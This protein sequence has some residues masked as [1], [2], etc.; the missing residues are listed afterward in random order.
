MLRAAKRIEPGG[1]R[2]KRAKA[3][4]STTQVPPPCPPDSMPCERMASRRR[5]AGWQD[6]KAEQS[7]PSHLSRKPEGAKEEKSDRL[8][9]NP[10]GPAAIWKAEKE[11]REPAESTSMRTCQRNTG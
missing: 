1:E 8:A 3:E 6:N 7:Q 5:L 10:R 2:K 11:E 4:Y 9:P